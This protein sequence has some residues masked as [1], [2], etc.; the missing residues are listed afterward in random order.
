MCICSVNKS[1]TS[2]KAA[3]TTL[4]Q[5][6]C[7]LSR[8]LTETIDAKMCPLQYGAGALCEHFPR[9]LNPL[10]NISRTS[11]F[12][13][14]AASHCTG[15]THRHHPTVHGCRLHQG[16]KQGVLQDQATP[17]NMGAICRKGTPFP[18]ALP[19]GKLP[20]GTAQR[21]FESEILFQGLEKNA[22]SAKVSNDRTN[23]HTC[24]QL[25]RPYRSVFLSAF[26]LRSRYCFNTNEW[27]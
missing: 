19:P 4:L 14:C 9:Q 7:Y 25:T 22:R 27:N 16:S 21:L 8:I 18:F 6:I 5:G 12:I 3:R 24:T 17:H 15:A 20:P 10:G 1:L 11:L 2:E 23:S 13:R 26:Y